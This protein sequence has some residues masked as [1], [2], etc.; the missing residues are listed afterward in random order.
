MTRVEKKYQDQVN[1]ETFTCNGEVVG[2]F[3]LTCIIHE[4]LDYYVNEFSILLTRDEL[5]E[6]LYDCY[7]IE[8]G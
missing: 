4:I 8:L 3:E 1:E 2:K 7:N 5:L 6:E